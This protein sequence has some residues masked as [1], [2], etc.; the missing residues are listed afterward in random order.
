MAST[1]RNAHPIQLRF[2]NLALTI[3]LLQR[4]CRELEIAGMVFHCRQYFHLKKQYYK[5]IQLKK[6]PMSLQECI[7][8]LFLCDFCSYLK[9]EKILSEKPH[10]IIHFFIKQ[11]VYKQ[12]LTLGTLGLNY[13]F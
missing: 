8:L 9:C 13:R 7:A 1:K 4:H 2:R 10:P 3:V 11:P 12:Q 5:N 6:I